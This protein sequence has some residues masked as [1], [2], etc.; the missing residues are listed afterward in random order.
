MK[1][2]DGAKFVWT[3][4]GIKELALDLDFRPGRTRFTDRHGFPSRGPSDAA[5]RAAKSLIDEGKIGVFPI[6]TDL[7]IEVK[8]LGSEEEI[9]I[10]E[11]AAALTA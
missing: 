7:T 9:I 4:G 6:E 8:G 10:L 1:P 3:V 11:G 2:T 5:I